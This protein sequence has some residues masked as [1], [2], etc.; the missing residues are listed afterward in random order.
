LASYC[1]FEKVF[2]YAF[3]VNGQLQIQRLH[4]ETQP[5]TEVLHEWK[6]SAAPWREHSATIRSMFVPVTEALIHEAEISTGQAVLDVA[7]GTGEPSLAIAEVVGPT[8]LVTCTDA[9]AEMVATAEDEARRLGLTNVRFQQCTAESLPFADNTFDATVSRLGAMFFPDPVA[10]AREMLRVTKPEGRLCFVVWGTSDRNPYSY[11]ILN[12]L[13]RHVEAPA[14]DPDAP[15]AFRFAEP[16]KLAR[17]LSEAG[18]TN[19]R[20]RELSFRMKAPISAAQF[21]EMRSAISGSLREKL[22]TLPAEQAQRIRSEVQ[23]AVREFFPEAKMNF[24][25]EMLIVSARK[26]TV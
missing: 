13:S 11:A 24:P 7:G 25:A 5:M 23:E 21:W 18:A 26:A 14:E 10:A 15:G 12:V 22:A 20:E 6:D 9:V 8:G 16:G 3:G 17:V 1:F 19:V 4:R 2:I